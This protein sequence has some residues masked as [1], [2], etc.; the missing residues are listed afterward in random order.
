MSAGETLKPQAILHEG[1][2]RPLQ[3]FEVRQIIFAEGNQHAIIAA[4]EI[5]FLRIDGAGIEPSF[6]RSGW[7]IFNKICEFREKCLRTC[8]GAIGRGPQGEQ[9]F[10]L[11]EDEQGDEQLTAA[12]PQNVV[13]MMKIFP[14]R[15]AGHGNAALRPHAH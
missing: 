1:G 4:G 10:K 14:E 2:H 13:A 6:K 8:T 3:A 11:I 15:L 9:F 7:A 12:A 5:K